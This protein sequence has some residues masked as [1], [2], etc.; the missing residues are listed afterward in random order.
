MYVGPD[1]LFYPSDW[2][3]PPAWQ[4]VPPTLHQVD[5]PNWNT[6]GGLPPS[7][8]FTSAGGMSPYYQA[9]VGGPMDRF[10]GGV[11]PGPTR[12]NCL[13]TAVG[14]GAYPA[15]C[16]VPGGVYF[17]PHAF[18]GAAPPASW[19]HP[20]TGVV[21][22]VHPLGCPVMP[23]AVPWF[24]WQWRLAGVQHRNATPS[25]T[26]PHSACGLKQTLQ[27]GCCGGQNVG[28]AH[29]LPTFNTSACVELCCSDPLC[30]VA[31]ITSNQSGDGVVRCWLTHLDHPENFEPSPPTEK[32]VTLVTRGGNATPPGDAL[33]FGE[34]GWQ[35]LQGSPVGSH[36]F[37]ENIRELLDSEG[38][39]FHDNDTDTLYLWRNATQEAEAPPSARY[40]GSRLES[41]VRIV[42]SPTHPARAI[43][44]DGIAF[45]HTTTDYL[46]PHEGPGGG[47][48]AVHRGGAV[49]IEG[50]ANVTVQRC[51]FNRVDGSGVF[52]SRWARDVAILECEFGFTGSAG[53]VVMGEAEWMDGTAGRFPRRT[54]IRNNWLHDGG[55]WSKNYLGG[56]VFL[57]LQSETVVEGNVIYNTPRSALTFNDGFGGGDNVTMNLLFNA[58]RESADTG[59][60]Y[61]YNRLP[62]LTTVRN[63]TP[64]LI[65]AARAV[66]RNLLIA[67]Y[68]TGACLD[69][70][71]GSSFFD[72][73]RN[74]NVYC[75][76][77]H[78][79]FLNGAHAKNNSESIYYVNGPCDYSGGY[80]EVFDANH[81]FSTSTVSPTSR[82][83][84]DPAHPTSTP[85][86]PTTT[87]ARRGNIYHVPNPSQFTVACGAAGWNLSTSQSKGY[88]VGS[89]VLPLGGA[90]AG[91]ATAVGLARE[92][93]GM[94]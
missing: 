55:V 71:D 74:V 32:A 13:L 57:A 8:E 87:P 65:P 31:V 7:V 39:W 44:L 51:E 89:V 3:A 5:T 78:S 81:C 52:V 43:R 88:E 41:A 58:N 59:V 23:T 70:D 4:L 50:A 91:A 86:H 61:T 68:G 66:E 24:N 10:V 93:L 17:T 1:D 9:R 75:P 90:A 92:L 49:L 37:V 36:F 6:E 12:T 35:A 18:D 54:V 45:R 80:D 69:N 94:A 47:D 40:V 67:N 19:E 64:S 53:V 60:V 83:P 42:G 63:G 38:E 62:F 77:K 2:M 20:E 14:K 28:A 29:Q 56:S 85:G 48:Q 27:G 72:N 11:N 16:A 26:P 73:R 84:C 30:G 82:V 15:G 34:G 25:P 21:H 79:T 33:L 22:A 46:A 76:A